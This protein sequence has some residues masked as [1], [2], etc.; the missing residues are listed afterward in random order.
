MPNNFPRVWRFINA[1]VFLAAA[2]ASQPA[3]AQGEG[4]IPPV[5]ETDTASGSTENASIAT[6]TQNLLKRALAHTI[7]ANRGLRTAQRVQ[8]R[9]QQ[10][11]RAARREVGLATDGLVES[12]GM[13][14]ELDAAYNRALEEAPKDKRLGVIKISIDYLRALRTVTQ[15]RLT[16]MTE[17]YAFLLPPTAI[18]ELADPRSARSLAQQLDRRQLLRWQYVTSGALLQVEIERLRSVGQRYRFGHPQRSITEISA[19]T[20]QVML[21]AFEAVSAMANDGLDSATRDRLF[22]ASL[23]Q[24]RSWLSTLDELITQLELARDRFA[25]RVS[26]L[27]ADGARDQPIRQTIGA[28]LDNYQQSAALEREVRQTLIGL[29][30]SLSSGRAGRRSS[31]QVFTEP[32]GGSAQS[33]LERELQQTVRELSEATPSDD[34]LLNS[35]EFYQNALP[36]LHNR[37]LIL[38]RDRR[39]LLAQYRMQ[40]KNKVRGLRQRADSGDAIAAYE[41]GMRLARGNDI[42]RD[43][44]KANE[45]IAKSAGKG[46][47]P[48]MVMLGRMYMRGAGS[49]QD[50]A[51]AFSWFERAAG[52]G[53]AIAMRYVGGLYAAGR[54]VGKD[55]SKAVKMLEKAY[56]EGDELSG[57]NLAWLLAT[58]SDKQLRHPERAIEIASLL[59]RLHPDHAVY[60]D[61]LAAAFAATGDFERAIELQSRAVDNLQRSGEQAREASYLERLR[62]FE[63]REAYVAP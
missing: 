35:V 33:S 48:A 17:S 62:L 63:R 57:N 31:I 40:A 6:R 32:Q 50:P 28:I 23:D 11:L 39:R 29:L 51:R 38:H 16:A 56:A 43:I 4:S 9:A 49:P 1:T 34:E 19:A 55:E 36:R 44:V 14:Q 13:L 7:Q 45:Y 52:A 8:F 59:V 18:D 24:G 58:T 30:E 60:L 25:D 46:H 21:H 47:P 2:A 42:E 41:Y 15:A 61:T 53:D 3:H 37:R 22:A 12:V 5:P 20:S 10:H 27:N 26:R 54:G